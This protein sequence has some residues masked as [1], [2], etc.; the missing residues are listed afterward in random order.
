MQFNS[1]MFPFMSPDFIHDTKLIVSI[2][3]RYDDNDF[4]CRALNITISLVSRVSHKRTKVIF[5]II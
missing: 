2:T 5:R 4:P 1:H 3:S